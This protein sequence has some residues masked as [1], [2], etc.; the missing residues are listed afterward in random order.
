MSDII[1]F[2]TIFP[3]SHYCM[4]SGCTRNARLMLKKSQS[5]QVVL[6]TLD[7]GAVP[8]WSTHLYCERMYSIVSP[9]S[10]Y[11]FILECKVNYHRNFRVVD[12]QRI[13]HNGIP[14]ILQIG[15]HQFAETCVINTWISMMLFSWT[16][17][18]NCAR[19]Y[20]ETSQ[21]LQLGLPT[22]SW[23]FNRAVTS[24]Q[25]YD[26]FTL[27][28]LLE[29][30]QIQKT[31]LVV[32]HKGSLDGANRFTE[33]VHA[34]NERLKLCSQPELFHYCNKCTRFYTGTYSLYGVSSHVIINHCLDLE[35]NRKVSVVV[36]DGVCIGH[37]CCG[38]PKCKIPLKSTQD[39]H[40]PTHKFYDTVCAVIGCTNPICAGS[41][42]CNLPEHN[43]AEKMHNDQGKSRFQLRERLKRAQLACPNNSVSDG[44]TASTEQD[45]G[46]EGTTID[47]DD[48]VDSNGEVSF[49]LTP[50]GRTIPTVADVQTT[51]RR[52]RAQF[53]RKR[54]HNEQL[55]VAPCGIIIARETFYHS[56]ALSSVI[57]RT[58]I[59]SLALVMICLQEMIK[60]TYR[61]P[62]TMPEHI[63]YDN[64][65]NIA[66]M[67]K[68]DPAFKNV[69]LTVDV[70]HFKCKHSEKDVFCQEHCNPVAYP[71]LLGTAGQQWFFNSSVAEQTNAWLGG[72]HSICRE[73]EVQ[74]YNFFLDEMIRRRNT[75]TLEKLRQAGAQPGTRVF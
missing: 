5:R 64:N 47:T 50:D 27:L 16:S 72:Y 4:T 57:V 9:S 56:E 73:M 67:V 60:R 20:N 26:A 38:V 18:T 33:A 46:V 68:N 75:F 2:D 1:A 34:R 14:D 62:G 53:G 39:R 48:F 22:I 40:C 44:I 6:F 42:V 11:Y 21:Q 66:K 23:P 49:E 10:S 30:C 51:S 45:D 69:G 43:E 52:L 7:R 36:I 32:P 71:E 70:F 61:L 13:Y 58:C 74:R 3:L 63:F 59:L 31:T 65:C 41:K 15:E 19:I 8:V 55:F 25:I 35:P 28:S 12:K 37:P 54:T 24:T 17:A 29:D